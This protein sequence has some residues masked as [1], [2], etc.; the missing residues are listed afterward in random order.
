MSEGL[1]AVLATGAFVFVLFLLGYKSGKNKATEQHKVEKT[2]LE[3]QTKNAEIKTQT[4]EKKAELATKVAETVR[5]TAIQIQIHGLDDIEQQA[6]KP[7]ADA[8]DIARQ[9]AERARE[10]ML[11]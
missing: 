2:K 5:D 1:G 8:F 3:A 9:Q 11:R 4:A 10:F 7:D 6:A